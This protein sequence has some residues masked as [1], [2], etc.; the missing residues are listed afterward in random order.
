[1][2]DTIWSVFT[3]RLF[4]LLLIREITLYIQGVGCN[5]AHGIWC[6]IEQNYPMPVCCKWKGDLAMAGESWRCVGAQRALASIV[7]L[8]TA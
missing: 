5:L 4:K 7:N 3:K 8:W 2:N 6:H 1:M